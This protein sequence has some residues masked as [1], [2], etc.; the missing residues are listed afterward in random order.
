MSTYTDSNGVTYIGSIRVANADTASA[1][2]RLHAGE[3]ESRL[4]W[5]RRLVA[6]VMA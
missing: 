5:W 6:M 2:K 3:L 4:T 1:L